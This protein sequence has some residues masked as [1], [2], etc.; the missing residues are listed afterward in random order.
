MDKE[1]ALNFA[2]TQSDQ[3]NLP[4]LLMISM[5]NSRYFKMDSEEYSAFPWEEEVLIYDGYKYKI[6]NVSDEVYNDSKYT[7]IQLK[8]LS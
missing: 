7:F 6:I 1:I 2:L 8:I 4:V 3:N 5:S